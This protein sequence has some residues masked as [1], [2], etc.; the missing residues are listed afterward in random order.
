[1]GLARLCLLRSASI[2][3]TGG[4]EYDGRGKATVTQ[5]ATVFCA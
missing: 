1:M 3:E 2:M 4:L 5:N